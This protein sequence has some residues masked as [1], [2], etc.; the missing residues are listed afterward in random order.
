MVA[1]M[2]HKIGTAGNYETASQHMADN[3]VNEMPRLGLCGVGA[4]IE[5]PRVFLIEQ[6]AVDNVNEQRVLGL[7]GI[8]VRVRIENPRVFVGLGFSFSDNLMVLLVFVAIEAITYLLT[9]P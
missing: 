3:N 5:N 9:R 7:Y 4:T 8:G 1:K 6:R 2:T